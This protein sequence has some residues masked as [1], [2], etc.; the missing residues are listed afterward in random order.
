LTECAKSG[1]A[2]L[3]L[4]AGQAFTL[5]NFRG[6]LIALLTSKGVSVYAF[7]PDYDEDSRAAIRALGARPMDYGV[8]RTGMNPILDL[9]ETAKLSAQLRKLRLQVSLGYGIKPATFG[10]LAAWLGGIGNRYAM[11]EGL[12]YLFSPADGPERLKRSVLRLLAR[13]MYKVALSKTRK[14]FFLNDDDTAEFTVRKLVK[15]HQ[16]VQLGAIGVDLQHW[17]MKPAV[18][19]PITFVMAARLLREKGVVQFAE[20]GRRVRALHPN[21]RFLLLG[22]LD[23]N[24]GA[25]SPEELRSWTLDGVI[26][27]PGHVEVGPWLER[28]SVFVLPSYYREGVPRSIQ[29]AMAMGRPV[30]TT[31]LPGCRDTVIDGRNGFLIPERDVEALVAAMLRFIREPA[32]I[33]RMGRVSRALAEERFDARRADYLVWRTLFGGE[34][35]PAIP[36]AAHVA[37]ARQG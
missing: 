11:I 24:P 30:I 1:G 8:S 6:T 3:A 20:A 28:S 37:G 4:I 29:E 16:V 25:V 12:G 23:A 14:V 2:N 17:T 27:W 13:R 36:A 21:V 26:E 32:L 9:Y 5:V 33:E 34:A 10:T 22:A 31:D 19:R 15:P 35:D 18:S 7:A